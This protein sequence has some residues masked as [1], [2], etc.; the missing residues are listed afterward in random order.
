[1]NIRV[2]IALLAILAALGGVLL[3]TD[4]QQ[5]LIPV[6]QGEEQVQL[7]TYDPANV[8]QLDVKRDSQERRFRKGDDGQW[9]LQ[10][11]GERANEAR[12]E[13]LVIGLPTLPAQRRI[14]ATEA[15]LT[16]YGLNSP[17]L[18]LGVSLKDGT[19]HE[20][21]IGAQTPVQTGYYAQTSQGGDVYVV[22]NIL[23]A[24]LERLVEQPFAPTP[25][26]VPPTRPSAT[27]TPPSAVPPK[28]ATLLP[29]PLPA[30]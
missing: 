27:P 30:R 18:S 12:I 24:E 14:T 29:M 28:G 22:P 2:T 9:L 8:A 13:N 16:E 17:R 6:K 5:Q 21:R 3:Y 15:D 4:R 23:V 11:Q 26:P 10:P 20:L 7:L 1:M 25:T 19:I